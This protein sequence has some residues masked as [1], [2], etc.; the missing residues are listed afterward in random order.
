MVEEGGGTAHG[1]RASPTKVDEKQ[2][3][4]LVQL[5]FI[6]KGVGL[7][8]RTSPFNGLGPELTLSSY[9]SKDCKTIFLQLIYRRNKQNNGPFSFSRAGK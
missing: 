7:C 9:E 3:I 8:R 6:S 2:A 5:P 1:V 4:V